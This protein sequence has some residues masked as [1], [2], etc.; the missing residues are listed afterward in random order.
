MTDKAKVGLMNELLVR[1]ARTDSVPP[2]KYPPLSGTPSCSAQTSL[3]YMHDPHMLKR[4]CIGSSSSDLSVYIAARPERSRQ[5]V[6]DFEKSVA[7]HHE[8]TR[9]QGK[10]QSLR[11]STPLSAVLPASIRSKSRTRSPAPLAA[12][13]PDP[14]R[15]AGKTFDLSP[16]FLQS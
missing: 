15:R 5:S 8:S 9:P 12:R 3:C 14:L 16:K 2:A 13:H 10:P 1:A 11:L 6:S 7:C 4:P